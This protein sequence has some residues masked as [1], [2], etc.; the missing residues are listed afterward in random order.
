MVVK[1]SV[2][3]NICNPGDR[4]DPCIRSVLE[5]TLDHYEVIFVDDGST[6]GISERLDTVAGVRNNVRVLHLPHTGS[7]VRGFNVGMAA[8]NGR[9]VYL[10]D[11]LDRLER[12]ALAAMYRRAQ[13]CEADVLVGRLVRDGGPP[14]T[15]FEADRNRADILSDKLLSLLTPHKLYRRAFL[16]EHRLGF[17]VPGGRLA[18]QTFALQT[19]LTAKIVAVMAEP[20][21]CHLGERAEQPEDPKNVL[22]ELRTLLDVLDAHTEGRQRE[23][24]YAHWMRSTLLRPFMSARFAGSSSERGKVVALHRELLL[25]RFP[26]HLDR[27]LPAHL[28]A[29]ATLLREGR[30]DKLVALANSARHTKV[31]ADLREVRW[32]A[33]TLVLCLA[34]ELFADRDQPVYFRERDGRLHWCPPAQVTKSMTPEVTDVT[35]AVSRARM[36]VYLRNEVTGAVYFVPVGFEVE[37]VAEEEG[38]RLRIVGEARVDV[39]TAAMGGP[40]Q[41]GHWEVHVRMYGGAHQ[42]RTRV[43][44]PEGPLTCLGVLA[45]APRQ[46][47]IV[48]CW[49]DAG[50][51]GL[52]VEPRSFSESIALVSPGAS[53]TRQSG[54]LYVVLP[55]P[56]VP[57]S[58]GPAMELVLRTASGRLREICAPAMVEPGVPGRVAGQLVAKVPVKRLLPGRDSLGPGAWLTSLRTGDSEVGLRFGLQMRGGTVQVLPAAQVDPQR[59]GELDHD[60]SLRRL[61]RRVPGARH[62]VRLAR[63]GKHRYLRD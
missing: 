45:L 27:Y 33:E 16:E 24:M 14:L 48:P 21:C 41:T 13:E 15:A 10:L 6:D 61:A 23:R 22:A 9:Y 59:R 29:A 35:G 42:D 39:A 47:L 46:R 5:Q 30:V 44:R 51:L 60:T 53:V 3:V 20:V 57:P 7:R 1:V 8:A 43:R 34:V 11:Q 32:D 50:E 28:R 55:V 18:E 12:G 25:E 2:V 37:R 17:A 58:G 31:H 52:A 40:L 38:T 19:Y 36:E 63:A 56:Y 26:E 54:H 4:A 49:S 62:L